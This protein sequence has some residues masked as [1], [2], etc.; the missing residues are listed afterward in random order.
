MAHREQGVS[1]SAV[2]RRLPA[3]GS[4]L[5]AHVGRILLV[6]LAYFVVAMLIAIVARG[7]DMDQLRSRS[8]WSRVAAAIHDVL[9]FPHDSALRALPNDWLAHNTYFIPIALVL[10]CLAWGT[11][12]YLVWR[13]FRRS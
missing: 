13:A 8:V 6:S 11:M 10:N 9:W 1:R 7:L 5:W 3:R 2:N 12:L 4:R